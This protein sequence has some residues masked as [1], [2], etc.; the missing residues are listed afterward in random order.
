MSPHCCLVPLDYSIKLNSE[1]LVSEG[2]K[3]EISL[4]QF[5]DSLHMHT[6]LDPKE[7]QIHKVIILSYVSA[8]I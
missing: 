2:I 4:I 6:Y 5:K 3:A 1:G 7:W 8:W